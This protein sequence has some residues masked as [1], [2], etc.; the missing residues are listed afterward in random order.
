[1]FSALSFISPSISL[2]FSLF[3]LNV[4]S[5]LEKS[6]PRAVIKGQRK[7]KK[8]QVIDNLTSYFRQFPSAEWSPLQGL[9][10]DDN[11]TARLW[12]GRKTHVTHMPQG[13]EQGPWG[14]YTGN[15]F[16][17][18]SSIYSGRWRQ[19]DHLSTPRLQLPAELA[20]QNVAL[21]S[22]SW[23]HMPWGL[24]RFL[25][26]P[27]RFHVLMSLCPMPFP[28]RTLFSWLSARTFRTFP[29]IL[30]YLA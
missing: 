11:L 23:P 3:P 5:S 9:G 19:K 4:F 15:A 6:V 12:A 21:I 28:V 14:R 1:M 2:F 25:S 27:C 18:Q 22:V 29:F 8:G 7:M 16:E 20:V 30:K 24:W 13:V 17:V 26:A 10:T